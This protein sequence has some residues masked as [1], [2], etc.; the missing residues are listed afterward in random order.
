[1]IYRLLSWI[2]GQ[3]FLSTREYSNAIITFKQMD[4]KMCLKDNIYVVNSI[5]EARFYEGNDSAALLGF[6]RVRHIYMLL[7][8]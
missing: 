4:Q 5:A 8:V 6:Q 3:A 7:I 2:K 1:M